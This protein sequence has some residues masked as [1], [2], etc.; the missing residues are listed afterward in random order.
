M[1]RILSALALTLA[2]LPAMAQSVDDCDW[3]ANAAN[4]VEPWESHSR[5]FSNGAVRLA[6]L[7]TIE[8]GAAPVHLL[9]LSPPYDEL[10]GR[11]CKVISLEP[12][13]GFHNLYWE[14]LDARY[15]PA[16]GLVFHAPVEIWVDAGYAVVR[17][18]QVTL[19][20]ATGAVGA[21]IL[22]GSEGMK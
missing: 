4:I 19:N 6:L 22:D 21:V 8:P 7:D 9:L 1:R 12:G 15:D 3:R 11:M 14:D 10:G 2:A 13:I 17:G 20:Q 5:S 16:V 18:L